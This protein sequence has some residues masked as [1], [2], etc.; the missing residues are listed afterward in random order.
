MKKDVKISWGFRY[1]PATILRNSQ[2]Y[3]VWEQNENT[4]QWEKGS[5]F[6]ENIWTDEI[7]PVLKIKV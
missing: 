6:I 1:S 7:I 2:K 5:K 4:Y 3:L